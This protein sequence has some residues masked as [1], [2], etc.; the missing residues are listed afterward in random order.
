MRFRGWGKVSP[1]RATS[2]SPSMAEGREEEEEE[3]A[4]MKNSLLGS[5]ST[6][7]VTHAPN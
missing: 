1:A 4:W 6:P 5:V 7:C 3:D 2:S